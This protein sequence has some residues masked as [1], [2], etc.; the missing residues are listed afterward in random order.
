MLAEV[1]TN[2]A[3]PSVAGSPELEVRISPLNGA[4]NLLQVHDPGCTVLNCLV[5]E[6]D[7]VGLRPLKLTRSETTK[8]RAMLRNKEVLPDVVVRPP[9]EAQNDVNR[10][11]WE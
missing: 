8:E 2:A 5:D 1:V 10:Y 9:S 3:L 6:V 11:G 4:V 7:I